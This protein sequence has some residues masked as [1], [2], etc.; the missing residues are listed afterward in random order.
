MRKLWFNRKIPILIFYLGQ[1]R[2]QQQRRPAHQPL[3]SMRY[4]KLYDH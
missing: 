1:E 4:C 3:K 2:H